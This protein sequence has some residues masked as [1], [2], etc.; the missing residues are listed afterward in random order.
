[1]KIDLT[2]MPGDYSICRLEPSSEIPIMQD[3]FISVTKTEDE[4]SVICHVGN[5]P[6][7]AKCELNWNL[8][9]VAGPLDFSLV[10][11][12]AQI[13]AVLADAGISIFAISTFDT[14]YILVKKE[15]LD[16]ATQALSEKFLMKTY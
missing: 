14:D 10:G 6:S 5:E 2:L 11:I 8:L 1:M 13:S 16:C 7:G 9:K 15:N 12:L 4:L 3:G